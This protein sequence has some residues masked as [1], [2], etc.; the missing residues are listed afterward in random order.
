MDK[1]KSIDKNDANRKSY[2]KCLSLREE[3]TYKGAGVAILDVK[4]KLMKRLAVHS[5]VL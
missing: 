4:D 1:R 2:A 3:S 5:I